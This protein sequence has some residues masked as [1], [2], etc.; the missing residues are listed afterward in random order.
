M[1]A[2]VGKQNIQMCQGPD[3]GAEALIKSIEEKKFPRDGTSSAIRKAHAI[4][5]EQAMPDSRLK[6]QLCDIR[7]GQTRECKG[8]W[9]FMNAAGTCLQQN[10]RNALVQFDGY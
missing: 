1:L 5:V 2:V 7:R 9:L 10:Q 4:Q 8:L 6:Q 3:A